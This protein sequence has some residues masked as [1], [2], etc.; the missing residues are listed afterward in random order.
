M[1]RLLSKSTTAAPR[2]H[3]A[4]TPWDDACSSTAV[5]DLTSLLHQ[6][7][8]LHLLPPPTSP[9][10]PTLSPLPPPPFPTSLFVDLTHLQLRSEDLTTAADAQQWRE[11]YA[12]LTG[13]AAV[14][15]RL[16]MTCVHPLLLVAVGF[17]R[18]NDVMLCCVRVCRGVCEGCGGVGR[19]LAG[20]EGRRWQRR[21]EGSSTVASGSSGPGRG[22]PSLSSPSAA[23]RAAA[24]VER[25]TVFPSPHLEACSHPSLPCASAAVA[26]LVQ[27]SGVAAVPCVWRRGGGRAAASRRAMGHLAAAPRTATHGQ[28]S[29]IHTLHTTCP[30]MPAGYTEHCHSISALTLSTSLSP[31][32]PPVPLQ[33]DLQTDSAHQHAALSQRVRTHQALHQQLTALQ[34]HHSRA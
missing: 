11:A 29:S 25:W 10:P 3:E 13:A 15:R 2:T 5:P 30:Y 21:W 9:F 14:G 17:A 18:L 20:C 22:R 33:R 31:L 8:S 23:V 28:L 6:A 7:N 4:A 32:P 1:S 34:Q 19:V 24:A 27:A 16:R 12:H 26:V